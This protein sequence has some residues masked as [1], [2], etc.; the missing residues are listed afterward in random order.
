MGVI[1]ETLSR[2]GEEVVLSGEGGNQGRV[3]HHMREE[4]DAVEQV[5]QP[6][7]V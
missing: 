7:G 5:L 2:M 6:L 3:G 1:S 4:R